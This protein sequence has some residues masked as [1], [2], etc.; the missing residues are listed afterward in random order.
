MLKRE[1]FYKINQETLDDFYSD[2]LQETTLYI[3]PELNAIITSNP[4][5]EVKQYLYV[6][7]KINSSLLKKILVFFYTRL[8]LNTK[9]LLSSN[10]CK[11]KG[12]VKDDC[13][14]YPCNK[15]FRIF[16]FKNNV[17]TVIPKS[18]FPDKDIR[19][20]IEFRTKNT[21]GF[22]PPIIISRDSEYTEKI[23]DGYPL[24]RAGNNFQ[25]K[26]EEAKNIWNDYI[27]DS[28]EEISLKEYSQQL[29]KNFKTLLLEE[30]VKRKKINLEELFQL[31][32]MLFEEIFQD[33]KIKIGLSHGDLQP[34]NIWIENKTE[35]IYIIDWESYATRSLWYDE[36]ALAEN[37][38]ME[39]G[40]EK[41]A[42]MRGLK[43]SVV[44]YEDLIFHLEELNNLPYDYNSKEFKKYV[45]SVLKG[46]KNV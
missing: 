28:V 37:L 20:E 32:E 43:Y 44:L 11:V 38:R 3:Y 12:V 19:K 2:S 45:Q 10:T 33:T 30:N 27:K 4:S 36:C 42:E 39:S 14:I 46:R 23:I 15:K 31:E 34:G 7:Y 1:D 18:G 13:L 26:K 25:K 35:N 40:V 5:K 29:R 21:A 22:I 9:G 8:S 24:A 17:V 41:L 6:E 16:D